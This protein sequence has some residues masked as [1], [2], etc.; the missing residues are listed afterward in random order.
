MANGASVS[1]DSGQISI[2]ADGDITLG[3]LSTGNTSDT[4]V[5]LITMSGAIVDGGDL[6][7]DVVANS[8]GLVIRS[9]TGV[10]SGNAIETSVEKL[11]PEFCCWRYAVIRV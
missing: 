6:G 11:M 7:I 4:A 10:G 9:D 5:E 1:S 2:S 8:G 3:S